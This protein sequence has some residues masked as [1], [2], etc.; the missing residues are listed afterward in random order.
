MSFAGQASAHEASWSAWE[1]LKKSG[2][3]LLLPVFGCG[4]IVCGAPPQ[5]CPKPVVGELEKPVETRSRWPLALG[6]WTYATGSP[7]AK[8]RDFSVRRERHTI[9][10]TGVS[11][12]QDGAYPSHRYDPG[13]DWK[14]QWNRVGGRPPRDKPRVR[15]WLTVGV[16]ERLLLIEL[17]QLC[18]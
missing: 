6:A 15:R 10:S 14:M 1:R 8:A 12:P 16:R 17:V 5:T 13:S 7:T 3:S 9:V 11:T 18:L 2:M 4:K